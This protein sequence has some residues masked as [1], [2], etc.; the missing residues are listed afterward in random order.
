MSGSRSLSTSDTDGAT[1]EALAELVAIVDRLRDPQGGCPWDLAQTHSSLIPYVLEEAHEVAD[2]IRQGDDDHLAEEL[3]D[4]LLQVV[5]HARIASETERFD[6]AAVAS[7]ITEKLVRRHPHVFDPE[8]ERVDDPEA[9]RRS[10]EV[11]K[12]AER[13]QPATASPL[14][15][16]LALKV[17]GQP[18][19]AGAMTI[20]RKAAAAGFEWDAIEGVWAKVQEEMDELREAVASGDRAHAQEELGDVLFTLVNVARW[21]N[22][23]PEEGLAGTNRRF[24]DRFSRVEAALGG[25]LGGRRLAELEGHWQAAKAQIR[26][27]GGLGPIRPPV[28]PAVGGS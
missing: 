27:E 16:R 12:A 19:L 3:G 18:A 23:D 9:V 24:L 13:Q 1:L 5:L 17:R 6:L 15:D 25:D 2:A 14:S 20:S 10:W 26:A 21:C 11:I 4:L 22:L 8:A 7:A 28:D